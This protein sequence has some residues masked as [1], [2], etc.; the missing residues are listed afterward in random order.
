MSP[1]PAA[2]TDDD[3]NDRTVI[4]ARR[5]GRMLGYVFVLY[6]VWSLGQMAK[7]W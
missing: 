6:L 4:L 7:L 3:D 1:Y 2:M 5:M